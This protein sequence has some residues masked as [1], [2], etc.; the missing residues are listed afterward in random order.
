[1]SGA[2][3]ALSAALM[4]HGMLRAASFRGGRKQAPLSGEH[5]RSLKNGMR[6]VTTRVAGAA[7]AGARVPSM[8]W[9][10]AGLRIAAIP[11]NCVAPIRIGCDA[12][13]TVWPI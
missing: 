10:K 6:R 5:R 7:I 13:Y 9:V 1:M 12:S 4:P 8:S 2:A 3:S 11:E